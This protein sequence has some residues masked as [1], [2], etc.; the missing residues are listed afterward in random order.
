MKR[1]GRKI[2]LT[3]NR[4]TYT[5]TCTRVYVEIIDF[6]RSTIVRVKKKPNDTL[7]SDRSNIPVNDS[8]EMN[9]NVARPLYILDGPHPTCR[10]NVKLRAYRP[11]TTELQ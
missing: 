7:A 9:G 8:F 11:I 1:H 10:L 5:Y 6:E 4:I 2:D 3:I